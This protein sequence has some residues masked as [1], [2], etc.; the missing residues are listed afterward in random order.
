MIAMEVFELVHTYYIYKGDIYYS[1]RL[2][3]FFSNMD[4]VK[5]AV[6][7]Y[8]TK[9]GY[10]DTPNGFAIRRRKI[11][12]DVADNTFFEVMVYSHTYGYEDYEYTAELGLFASKSDAVNA[13]AQYHADNEIFFGNTMMEIEEI[14]NAHT[15][16]TRYC[17]EGFV[18]E[19]IEEK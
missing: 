5:D 18:V 19:K 16:D 13:L 8:K 9:P 14:V 11:I 15:M 17:E 7:Y 3:G 10:C 2:L 1:L 6:T 12:G 4:K